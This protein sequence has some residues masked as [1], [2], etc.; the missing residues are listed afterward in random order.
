MEL[1]NPKRLNIDFTRHFKTCAIFSVVLFLVSAV[2]LIKPGLNYGIDF[3]GGV[4]ANVVFHQDVNIG[5]LRELLNPRMQNLAIVA[6]GDAADGDR[7]F[8]VTAQA[9]SQDAVTQDLTGTLSERYGPSG[10]S[11]WTI[12]RMDVVGARVGAN[13]RMSALLSILYTCL[14]ITLYMYWRFDIRF[15]PGALACIFHDLVIVAGILALTRMEFSTTIV[16]ALLTLAGYSINDTVVIFDRIREVEGKFL[17]RDKK[18]IVNHAI[19]STL[20]RTVMTSTTTL[21]TC[22]VLYFFG[23]STL[24]DFATVLFLGIVISTYSTIFVS[25]PLYLWADKKFGSTSSSAL[26][27]GR[28]G[29]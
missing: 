15:S 7:E 26:S 12:A 27:P 2:A 25:T 8:L 24:A 3:R 11:T 5:E 28:A 29:S 14:L 23:G 1:F 18:V 13:L 21:G 20:S 19:N 22:L 4:E 10:A 9:E 17:G 16:A 6:F